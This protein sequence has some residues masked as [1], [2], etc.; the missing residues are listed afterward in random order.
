MTWVAETC[1]K[2]LSD[3]SETELLC[4]CRSRFSS[5]KPPEQRIRQC[6]CQEPLKTANGLSG[7]NANSICLALIGTLKFMRIY[8]ARSRRPALA[9][10]TRSGKRVVAEDNEC[11]T[12]RR[13]PC[14][15]PI[16]RLSRFDLGICND[17][18][19]NTHNVMYAHSP[20]DNRCSITVSQSNRRM[21]RHLFG[22]GLRS[23]GAEN[24]EQWHI[25]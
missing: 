14:S 1:P 10:M 6:Q 23:F 7:S 3:I 17:V 13:S 15:Y 12:L 24:G 9:I 16:E 2:G 21:L 8:Q 4:C 19:C 20:Y 18:L 5:V 22:I 11:F 25:W